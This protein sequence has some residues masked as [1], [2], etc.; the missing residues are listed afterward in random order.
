MSFTDWLDDGTTM[1]SKKSFR[2]RLSARIGY[3]R[4][5]K[6]AGV[7]IDKSCLISP[8]AR[9]NARGSTITIGEKT[10]ISPYA[11]IQGNVTVGRGCS[12]Q[13][14]SILVGYGTSEDRVG[15]IR[16][17]NDVRIASH[18]MIVGANHRF[19]DVSRPIAKQGLAR[20]SV[21]IEDDVWIGG[22]V[23]IL[24]GVTI[25]RG[26]V[27]AAGAVVTHDVPPYSVVAG[28]PAKVIKKRKQEDTE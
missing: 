27:V 14:Y 13:P 21:V 23:N 5:A 3:C 20:K 28:V 1:P 22:R 10:S 16:I 25:G 17:G 8:S 24:A 9:I 12:V 26:S 2:H 19:D 7:T 6:R 11:I 15:E 18:V 4:A